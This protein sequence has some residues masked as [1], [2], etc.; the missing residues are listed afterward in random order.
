MV[1]HPADIITYAKFR[2]IFRGYDFIGGRISHFPIDF[3]MGFTTVQ[4][5]VINAYHFYK[6]TNNWTVLMLCCLLGARGIMH[7]GRSR[8]Y[9]SVNPFFRICICGIIEI[10]QW[11]WPQL[12][13]MT[14]MILRRSRVQR[15]KL[16]SDGHRN[17]ANIIAPEPLKRLALKLSQML[18]TVGPRTKFSRSRVQSSSLQKTF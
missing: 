6:N 2:D 13:H 1:G 9:A 10:F 4:L 16:V 14:L 8:A 5:P 17:L 12:Q 7:A 3:C 18:P 11:N 15:S